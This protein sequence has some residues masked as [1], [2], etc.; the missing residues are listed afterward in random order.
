MTRDKTIARMKPELWDMV[1]DINLTAIIEVT[2][3]L[4]D[5][6]VPVRVAG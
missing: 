5:E 2:T 4:L 3:R 1:I 6:K